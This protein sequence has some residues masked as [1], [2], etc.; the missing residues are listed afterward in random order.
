MRH[1]LL[2]VVMAGLV[3]CTTAASAAMIVE[4]FDSYANGTAILAI[5]NSP[6]GS[7]P[8]GPS[9]ASNTVVAGGGV[10]GSNGLSNA[11][12]IFNWKAQPFNWAGFDNGK[13][14]MMAMDYKTSSTGKFDDNRVGWTINADSATSSANQLALQV[15]NTTDGGM[16]TYWDTVRVVL[17]P[18]ANIKNSTWYRFEVEYTKLSNTS[19]RMVGT[20]TELDA[21]GNKTGTPYVGTVADTS[22]LGAN[23]PTVAHFTSANQWPSY[24]CYVSGNVADNASFDADPVP[25][26]STIVL[27]A[28]G[29]VALCGM[30]W[31]KRRAG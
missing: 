22:A 6:T 17:D 20:L 11:S 9:T 18:L 1:A 28:A 30:A 4:T 27:V 13:K 19:A 12:P 15:D 29:L 21:S 8:W 2:F 10:A 5:P 23:S 16:V 3:A 26:P 25:E 24:K 14:I 7:G 31:R